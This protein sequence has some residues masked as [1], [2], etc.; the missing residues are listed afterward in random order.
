MMLSYVSVVSVLSTRQQLCHGYDIL[1]LAY[2]HEN[3][4]LGNHQ[5]VLFTNLGISPVS[6]QLFMFWLCTMMQPQ[7]H[8]SLQFSLVASNLSFF[9][10]LSCCRT[11][12]N[13]NKRVWLCLLL[14]LS[15]SVWERYAWLYIY[16][17]NRGWLVMSHTRKL[18]C[19]IFVPACIQ[20]W[21]RRCR[22]QCL[23]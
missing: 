10:S 8:R 19:C 7:Q 15:I 22:L 4:L 14:A 16:R 9:R 13:A 3:T 5:L 1:V 12:L 2:G 11:R 17:S 23:L 6:F 20:Q 21:R 18:C